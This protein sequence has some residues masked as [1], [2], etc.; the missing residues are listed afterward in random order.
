VE[1]RRTK[2][3]ELDT[4]VQEVI[5]ETPDTVTLVLFAGHEPHDYKAGQFINVDV[6]QFPELRGLVTFFEEVKK[7][8]EPIRSYSLAS[9][10]HE[11]NLA[12][13]IKEEGYVTGVTKY[14]PLLSPLLVHKTPVG[15]RIKAVGYTGPYVLPEDVENR[16]DH[17]VHLVAGSGSV[18]NY[19]ILKDALHRG[20]KLRHT[21]IYSNK[22]WD[23]I[24]FRAGLEDLE[25]HHPDKLRVV[26]TLT[27]E[28]DEVRFGPNVRRGRIS[29][30]LLKELIPDPQTCLVY[31]CGPAITPWDRRTALETKVP[32]KPRFLETALEYLHTLGITNDRIK[33]ESY[34]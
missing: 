28:Q 26:H 31:L 22:S 10:P 6:H 16:T 14:P 30:E 15:T 1:V 21:F 3:H 2:I 5:V 7:R 13:T 27:R 34:G 24:C 11:K 12:I 9:A 25:K 18:P 32:A 4:I 17:I 23:D 20:L 33:R 29:L 19:S 8:K